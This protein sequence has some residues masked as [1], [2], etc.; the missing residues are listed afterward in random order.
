[1]ESPTPAPAPTSDTPTISAE[2]AAATGDDFAAFD[3]AHQSTQQGKPLPRVDAPELVKPEAPAADGTPAPERALSKRQEEAN[4]RTRTAVEAAT[5]DLRAEV[6]RLKASTAA[7]RQEPP[8]TDDAKADAERKA[9]RFQSM[10]EW[11]QTHPEGSLDDYLEDRDAYREQVRE[12]AERTR[13]TDE[14]RAKYLTERGQEYGERLQKAHQADPDIA[15]KI[16]PQILAARPKSGLA[17]GERVT[18]ANLVAETGLFSPDPAALYRYL[19][20]HQNEAA[21]LASSPSEDLALRALAQLDG[22][23]SA[24]TV[25]ATATT[26]PAAAEHAAA[27]PDTITKAP[28]PIRQVTGSSVSDPLASALARDDFSAFDRIDTAARLARR[29]AA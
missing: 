19:T 11:A 27:R 3:H 14:T 5:A 1:M 4:A 25:T 21:R 16:A 2:V 18:F 22:R 15:S 26:S 13:Q 24:G 6:E 8:K 28:A 10:A 9:P 20:E 23:L 7:P 12:T 29:G 17:P